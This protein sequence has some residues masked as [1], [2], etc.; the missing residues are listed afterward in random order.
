MAL[1][2]QQ[3]LDLKTEIETAEKNV[4]DLQGQRKA[5]MKQ[6]KED[7]KCSTLPEAREKLAG[8]KDE[9]QE[10]QETIETGI[11]ELKEQYEFDGL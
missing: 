11:T 9:I 10:L 4:S 7:W 6:L 8:I 3:L 2:K 1:S 5:L